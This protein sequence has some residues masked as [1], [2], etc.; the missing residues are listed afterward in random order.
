MVRARRFT[1]ALRSGVSIR[2]TFVGTGEAT[3]PDLPN[4]SLLYRGAKNLLVDCGYAVPHALWAL[5]RGPETLDGIYLSHLHADHAFGLPAVL[6]AMR[7]G[8]RRR[9]LDVLVA[10]GKALAAQR[11]ADLGFPTSFHPDKCFPIRYVEIPAEGLAWGH[12]RLRVARTAH[13][14]VVNHALRIDEGSH[15]LAYS[16]DGAPT[17]EAEALYRDVGTLVHECFAARAED[18]PQG[19]AHLEQV[20]AMA[21]RVGARE[22]CV[23]HLS[24]TEIEAIHRVAKTLCPQPHLPRPG[25]TRRVLPRADG[26]ASPLG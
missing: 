22:L 12:A 13:K 2:V 17:P 21:A 18:C 24:R 6:I 7:T 4:T 23:L 5:E 3:D 25:S 11:I 19:H 10:P 16:G 1:L 8:G 26:T 20:V 14:H 15:A 9:P